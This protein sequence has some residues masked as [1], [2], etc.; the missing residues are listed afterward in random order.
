MTVY[1]VPAANPLKSQAPVIEAL[2]GGQTI[3]AISFSAGWNGFPVD[4]RKLADN[5]ASLLNGNPAPH[6][7]ATA[8]ADI[9]YHRIPAGIVLRHRDPASGGVSREGLTM[10]VNHAAGDV[11]EKLLA[12]MTPDFMQ[13]LCA[14]MDHR[15]SAGGPS[16]RAPK[17]TP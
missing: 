13:S 2:D 16:G 8:Q 5:M 3:P 9:H 15:V 14:T 7:L 4:A 17:P 11:G 6:A 10:I 12:R 1:R